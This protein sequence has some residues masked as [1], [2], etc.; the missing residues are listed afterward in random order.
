MHVCMHIYKYIFTESC[1]HTFWIY[2]FNVIFLCCC[3]RKFSGFCFLV[4]HA[5]LF[6][7]RIKRGLSVQ[8]WTD[9]FHS[10]ISKI[11]IKNKTKQNIQTLNLQ[12]SEI[13]STGREKYKKRMYSNTSHVFP[14][15]H[16]INFKKIRRQVQKIGS[17][18]ILTLQ[19]LPVTIRTTSLA[20]NNCT[21]CPHCIYVFCIYLRTNSDLCQLQHKLIG[22][23]NRDEKCLQRC[24][25]WG[26]N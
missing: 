14:T 21:F 5:S 6:T 8:D 9:A 11:W 10:R 12:W 13:S 17:Q 25:V 22:F 23:Y 3:N 20:L 16:R 15:L 1:K 7:T 26:F 19:S 24:T 4:R 2:K 18:N